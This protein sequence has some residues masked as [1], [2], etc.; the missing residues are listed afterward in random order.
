MAED[1]R[2]Q[3]LHLPLMPAVYA[4][5]K[6]GDVAPIEWASAVLAEAAKSKSTRSAK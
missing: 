1:V 3:V 2:L 6:A 4:G 5:A